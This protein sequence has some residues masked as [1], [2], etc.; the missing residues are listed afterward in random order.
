MAD[1]EYRVLGSISDAC[2]VGKWGIG[3]GENFASKPGPTGSCRV[4]VRDTANI[5]SAWLLGDNITTS[6]RNMT[7]V[8]DGE[9]F[10]T[11]PCE[12]PRVESITGTSTHPVKVWTVQIVACFNT[13]SKLKMTI[14]LWI[15]QG[16]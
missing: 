5:V 13:D 2:H 11:I 14:W 8:S 16:L 15:K 10:T 4:T 9:V 3:G 1:L 7:I 12:Y 6:V